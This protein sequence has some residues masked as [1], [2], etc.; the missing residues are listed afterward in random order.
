MERDTILTV[1][2]TTTVQYRIRIEGEPEFEAVQRYVEAVEDHD[3]VL[4]A[5]CAL[6]HEGA[7][8]IEHDTN[9]TILESYLEV[10]ETST[11]KPL[12]PGE[13]IT[14]TKTTTTT[15]IPKTTP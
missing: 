10:Q 12:V 1:L 4:D 8:V 2:Q 15:V 9:G 14:I 13:Q 5:I 6:S 11:T 3:N 7:Q